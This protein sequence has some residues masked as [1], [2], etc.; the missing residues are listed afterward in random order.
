M[1]SVDVIAESDVVFSQGYCGNLC[2]RVGECCINTC[3]T[4]RVG[5]IGTNLYNGGEIITGF[6]NKCCVGCGSIIN[7]MCSCSN[8]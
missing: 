3:T 4:E 7:D 8:A 6:C 1:S 5:R 2:S